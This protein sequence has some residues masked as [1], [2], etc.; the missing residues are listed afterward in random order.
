MPPMV[1]VRPASLPREHVL[2]KGLTRDAYTHPGTSSAAWTGEPVWLVGRASRA[3]HVFRVNAGVCIRIGVLCVAARSLL[4]VLDEIQLSH[5][6]CE[7]PLM[8]LRDSHDALASLGL[9]ARS[10]ARSTLAA[11]WQRPQHIGRRPPLVAKLAARTQHAPRTRHCHPHTGPLHTKDLVQSPPLATEARFG[12]QLFSACLC[13]LLLLHHATRS[14]SPRPSGVLSQ[15]DGCLQTMR[16][17]RTTARDRSIR[18]Q[19][20]KRDPRT[21]ST[22]SN[23]SFCRLRKSCVR[24]WPV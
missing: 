21:S 13:L 5:L 16:P 8:L 10:S 6:L 24:E 19:G 14:A 15:R 17:H 23:C 12:P 20:R 22:L 11:R 18:A 4:D 3:G 9:R 1:S 2:L 7:F